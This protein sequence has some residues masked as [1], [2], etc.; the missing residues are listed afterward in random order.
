L[1]A[2]ST[3][4]SH[5]HEI[6]DDETPENLSDGAGKAHLR[7][8]HLGGEPARLSVLERGASDDEWSRKPLQNPINDSRM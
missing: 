4:A 1:I 8:L 2:E 6:E 7:L 5:K 3:G